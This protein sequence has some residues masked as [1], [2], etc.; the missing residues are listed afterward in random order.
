M[1]DFT[2][3]FVIVSSTHNMDTAA[4]RHEYALTYV[5]AVNNGYIQM[6]IGTTLDADG[7]YIATVSWFRTDYRLLL[8]KHRKQA[9]SALNATEE[10]SADTGNRTD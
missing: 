6:S 4:G 3:G 1:T 2:Q 5:E 9:T 8:D 7:N 10:D